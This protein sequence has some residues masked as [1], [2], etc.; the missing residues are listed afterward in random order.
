M[1]KDE[2]IQLLGG[3]AVSAA[4]LMGVTYQAVNKWPHHLP[5]RISDRVLGACVRRGLLIPL[6]F[7]DADKPA[8]PATQA[9]AAINPEAQQSAKGVAHG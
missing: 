4:R 7:I 1:L 9:Q 3:D 6:C 5:L 2:A 8:A